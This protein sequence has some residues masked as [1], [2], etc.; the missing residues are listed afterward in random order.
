MKEYWY[1]GVLTR[2]LSV[3]T[4]MWVFEQGSFY[5]ASASSAPPTPRKLKFVIDRLSL[6]PILAIIGWDVP[7]D[8]NQKHE[9]VGPT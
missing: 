7:P 1:C 8:R 4:V 9:F 2:G 3:L 6:L 5:L